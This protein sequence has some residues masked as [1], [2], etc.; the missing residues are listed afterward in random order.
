MLSRRPR[1]RRLFHRAC[2]LL[3][4]LGADAAG[5]ELAIAA[6]LSYEDARAALQSVSDL[7]KSG[8]V[9]VRKSDYEA[10]AAGSLG[11]P[12]LSVNAT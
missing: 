2:L 9:G 1:R 8:E 3:A 6:P 4:L 11:S 12:E 10:R 5:I 7:N